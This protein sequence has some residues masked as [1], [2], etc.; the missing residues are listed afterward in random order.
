MRTPAALILLIA[1]CLSLLLLTAP[2]SLGVMPAEPSPA[3]DGMLRSDLDFSLSGYGL[4]PSRAV[5]VSA[6]S[7]VAHLWVGEPGSGAM[8]PTVLTFDTPHSAS[9]EI[10]AGS[11]ARSTTVTPEPGTLTLALLGLAGLVV[12]R[13]RGWSP[14]C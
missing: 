3:D 12:M 2:V 8:G 6:F 1:L 11:T 9:F 4:G 7:V 10:V 13:R 5:F 14:A